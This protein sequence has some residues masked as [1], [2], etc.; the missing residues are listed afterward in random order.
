MEGSLSSLGKPEK[1]TTEEVILARSGKVEGK[2]SGMESE[3]H[4]W[5]GGME[6]NRGSLQRGF[7]L[8]EIR[9]SL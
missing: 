1:L 6:K 4:G 5:L 7:G 8:Q 2:G 3:T 9:Q